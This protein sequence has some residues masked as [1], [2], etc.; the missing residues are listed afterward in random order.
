ML[1]HQSSAAVD[2][3]NLHIS[4]R[5]VLKVAE[6]VF[7]TEPVVTCTTDGR[8]GPGSYHPFGRALDFR[9]PVAHELC[10]TII[11]QLRSALGR[12]Y[13]VVLEN[14]HIHVEYDPKPKR[15]Y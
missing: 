15:N 6:E 10:G 3:T 14:D 7:P 4:M 1:Y 11:I 12:D 2:I 5:L 9:L 13:D 8:H